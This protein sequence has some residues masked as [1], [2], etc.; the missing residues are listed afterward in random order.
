L[1][2]WRAPAKVNLTLRVVRRNADGWHELDSLVAFAGVSDWLRFEPGRDLSLTVDGPY[3]AASGLVEDNLVLRAARELAGRVG[4]LRLG[5]FRLTKNLPVAAGL[6]GG[7]ADAAAALRA[8]AH[9][10]GLGLDDRRL[11]EAATATGSDV[12]VCL[13]PRL[14]VMGGRGE[15][16][17][18]GLDW[19]PLAAVLANP[20]V[21]VS[22]ASVFA[23]MA[24]APGGPMSAPTP[25]AASVADNSRLAV[26]TQGRN[27][28][29]R[30]A[31]GLAP[32]IG[33]ALAALSRAA[34]VWLA[35]MSGSGATCFGLFD[36]RRA[37]ASAAR[38]LASENPGWWVRGTHL[39]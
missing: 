7:S 36:D 32:Q 23:A 10:S 31:R 3:A 13:E 9:E 29:E 20:G 35:R 25:L 8:L 22:T 26:L 33:D 2:L 37:A 18:P 19:P 27:D 39:R 15:K 28:M 21:D 30:A 16:V 34:G 38:T 5:R 24:L 12:P 1:S 11:R 14:R 17:G 6:G 4:D